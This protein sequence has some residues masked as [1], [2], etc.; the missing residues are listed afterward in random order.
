MIRPENFARTHHV[1]FVVCFHTQKLSKSFARRLTQCLLSFS[2]V[3]ILL[4]FICACCRQAQH[5]FIT[6]SSINSRLTSP[7]RCHCMNQDF[8][9]KVWVPGHEDKSN[10]PGGLSASRLRQ[11]Q[12]AIQ[13]RIGGFPGC[14]GWH[15]AS[16]VAHLIL[17]H[18]INHNIPFGR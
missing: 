4:E 12:C 9:T 1:L 11:P 17:T 10:S 6:E 3:R 15:P 14:N 5:Q 7:S 2:D 16:R 8:V 13:A 18:Y